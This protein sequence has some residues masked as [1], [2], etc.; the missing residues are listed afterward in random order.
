MYSTFQKWNNEYFDAVIEANKWTSIWS[1]FIPF[2]LNA[3]AAVFVMMGG[4]FIISSPI[5]DITIGKLIA[6][7]T[8]FALLGGPIRALTAF[9]NIYNTTKA[10]AQRIF[11]TMDRIPSIKDRED[12]IPLNT[13]KGSLEFRNV[14]FSYAQNIEILKGITLEVQPGEVVAVVGPSGVGKTTLVHLVP[15]F[16]DVT[17]GSILIDG[18]D[19]R[20]F[21][22][23]SLRKNVGVVMQNVFLFDGTISQNIAYGKPEATQEEIETAAKIAQI[24]DFILALPNKYETQ[25]EERGLRLSGGQAQRLAIARVLVTDPKLLILDEPTAN[26]DAITDQKLI[27]SVRAVMKGRTTI[28]IAHR[29]WTIKNANKIVLLKEGKIEAMGTHEELLHTSEFYREFFASQFQRS[30]IPTEKD[31]GGVQKKSEGVDAK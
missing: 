6:V 3:F 10:A 15:R 20:Q 31:A 9:V 14:H 22:L 1:P 26:V 30:D 16:Y 8:Y 12:A 7:I 11:E 28:I 23:K 2:I 5:S 24:D 17:D 18:T 29:L 21:Q 13:V 19:I 27:N 4:V 25:I